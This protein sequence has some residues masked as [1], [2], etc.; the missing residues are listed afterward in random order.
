MSDGALPARAPAAR[1]DGLDVLRALA[2]LSVL[3]FHAPEAIGDAV[4]P[5]MRAAFA[6]GW[7]GVDLFFV[8][9]GY[10]IGRQVFG[11]LAEPNLGS[12]L[13]A[14]WV[15]RW[16]RTLPLY[17][18]V[19]TFYALKPWTFG[20]PFVGGGWH[21]ALFLQNFTA[22]RDFVQ[23]WSLCVEE[24][25]YLVLPL[26]AFGLR[27]RQWPAVAWLVPVLVSLLG[28]WLVWRGL[29]S[30]TPASMLPALLYWPTHLHLDGL[31][32]G[33]F[34]A[35]TAPA[36]RPW[37]AARR[38]AC[39]LLGVAVLA[40]TIGQGGP[41]LRVWM[42]SGLAAGFALLL[43]G[44]ESARLPA[45][46]RWGVQQVAVLSYGAYLWHAPVVRIFERL[47]LSLGAWGL[48]LLAF[49]TATLAVAWVTYVTV[50]KPCLRLRD[51]L[52][53]RLESRTPVSASLDVATRP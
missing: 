7:M 20:T 11:P 40:L 19:L 38:T 37:S 51:R 16:V 24:H 13:R 8:L 45:V 36:W 44:V 53:S 1:L 46:P 6:H 34:L 27:G 17:F 29:P 23:S 18:V 28:R 32:M 5:A 39:G 9:S 15:K 2:I 30:G 41:L 33:V 12:R 22:P 14:F 47:H 26:L 4:A 43:V 50:E 10:L 21:Y 52:L 25:F 49:L 3:L 31:A 42:V 48:D 35:K